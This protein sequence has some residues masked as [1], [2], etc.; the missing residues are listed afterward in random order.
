MSN[1]PPRQQP[2]E[3][4]TNPYACRIESYSSRARGTQK[5]I[6]HTLKRPEKSLFSGQGNLVSRE[7][8]ALPYL[9]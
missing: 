5:G 6:Q 9:W 7:K 3:P 1:N 4:A 2:P 8:S